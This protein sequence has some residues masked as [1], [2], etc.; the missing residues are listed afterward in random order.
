MDSEKYA[1]LLFN[2]IQEIETD[3]DISGE[4]IFRYIWNSFSVNIN[5]LSAN[6]LFFSLFKF[7]LL[8]NYS[9]LPFL[10]TNFQIECI[11]LQPDICLK[12]KI[13]CVSLL[14]FYRSFLPR[15]KYPC[16]TIK[17]DSC[18]HYL[19]VPTFVSKYFQKWNT[20]RLKLE[21]SIQDGGISRNPFL[22]RT[23]KR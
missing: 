5:I 9:C 13:D 16:F 18:H 21:S 12:E 15:D 19:A 7:L 2:L 3:F 23:T 6:F 17:P 14:D 10:P 22:P 4:I 11:E 8:F 20:L 1:P